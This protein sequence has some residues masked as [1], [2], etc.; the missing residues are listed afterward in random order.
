MINDEFVLDK[1]FSKKGS[2]C[3]K[4]IKNLSEVEKQYLDNRFKDKSES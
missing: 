2:L 4:K 3:Y 1:F